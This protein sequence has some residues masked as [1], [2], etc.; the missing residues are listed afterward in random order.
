MQSGQL[1]PTPSPTDPLGCRHHTPGS[2]GEEGPGP[3]RESHRPADAVGLEGRKPA[4]AL[5]PTLAPSFGTVPCSFSG[6][7][8]LKG[9]RGLC[10]ET[11]C[12]P[13][14]RLVHQVPGCR[15]AGSLRLL[16][17][18]Q[19]RLCLS[20]RPSPP[21]LLTGWVPGRLTTWGWFGTVLS[22]CGFPVLV[23]LVSVCPSSSWM[24]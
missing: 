13:G 4:A 23:I 19:R 6:S 12:S 8:H 10:A 20:R 22:P 18:L 16:S 2:C 11:A 5:S 3:A 1:P 24:A 9:Q 21:S 17:H 14:W 15:C 7:F